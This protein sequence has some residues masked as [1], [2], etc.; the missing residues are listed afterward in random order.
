MSQ[1]T[2]EVVGILTKYSSVRPISKMDLGPDATTATGVRPSSVRS[3]DTSIARRDQIWPDTQGAILTDFA[4]SVH[5]PQTAR[6][7]N[8][9][10]SEVRQDHCT[11]NGRPAI[12]SSGTCDGYIPS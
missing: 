2:N 7:E 4:S 6:R 8:A 5:S 12:C 11:G 9:D 3:A 10:T 1:V